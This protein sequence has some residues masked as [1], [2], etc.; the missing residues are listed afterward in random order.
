MVEV[1]RSGLKEVT[2]AICERA[3]QGE[4]AGAIQRVLA[5]KN[6]IGTK[7]GKSRMGSINN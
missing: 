3:T 4:A 2:S 5:M 6:N 1:K 7:L